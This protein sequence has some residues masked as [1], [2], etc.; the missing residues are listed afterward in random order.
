MIRRIHNDYDG[1]YAIA[2]VHAE[3][4]ESECPVGRV[5]PDRCAGA[6]R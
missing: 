1:T 4:V 2:Q 5:N 3:L 6:V